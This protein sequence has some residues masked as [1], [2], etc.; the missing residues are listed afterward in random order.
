MQ[1]SKA[2][3]AKR[4]YASEKGVPFWSAAV[5]QKG[6]GPNPLGSF[7]LGC[8]LNNSEPVHD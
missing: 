3:S 6:L 5:Q 4:R 2:A 7:F 8:L 1:S